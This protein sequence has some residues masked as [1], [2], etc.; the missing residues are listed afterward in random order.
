MKIAVLVNHFQS[1]QVESKKFIYS[2][3]LKKEMNATL[4]FVSTRVRACTG[5]RPSLPAP[6]GTTPSGNS[7]TRNA[8]T[9]PNCKASSR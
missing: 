2:Y 8:S 4:S 1:Y 9:W 5:A 7:S 6:S 3:E